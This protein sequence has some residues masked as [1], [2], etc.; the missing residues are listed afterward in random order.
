[1]Q[2]CDH[3]TTVELMKHHLRMNSIDTT[4]IRLDVASKEIAE[5]ISFRMLAP[6]DL[7]DTLLQ[8]DLWPEGVRVCYLHKT[9]Q[10]VSK[11]KYR[12]RQY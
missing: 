9:L 12:H 3:S 6:N 2:L 10:A 4:D 7:R 11:L 1:M 8:P 5:F